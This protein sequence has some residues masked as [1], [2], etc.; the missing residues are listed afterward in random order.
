[1]N[2]NRASICGDP[3]A[4]AGYLYDEGSLDEHAAL[5][6]HLAMCDQ[7]RAEIDALHETRLALTA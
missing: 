6:A 5:T 1:M 3:A 7:C 4:L 2:A